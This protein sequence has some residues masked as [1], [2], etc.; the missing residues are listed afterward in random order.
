M[1]RKSFS[2]NSVFCA[3]PRKFSPSNH[4]PCTVCTKGVW[5]CGNRIK[6]KLAYMVSCM[7]GWAIY[8]ARLSSKCMKCNLEEN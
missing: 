6:C 7:Q 3:Q 2:V 1:Y 4:L 5:W 8:T